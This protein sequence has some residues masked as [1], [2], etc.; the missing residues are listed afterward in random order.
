MLKLETNQ[1]A[2]RADYQVVLE[3]WREALENAI[4]F[5]DQLV[6]ESPKDPSNFYTFFQVDINNFPVCLPVK[7]ELYTPYK[8]MLTRAT[9]IANHCRCKATLRFFE[10]QDG[11]RKELTIEEI[12]EKI[13]V[14]EK[15]DSSFSQIFAKSFQAYIAKQ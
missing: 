11:V 10:V 8:T 6:I 4:G 3:K 12:L 13:A 2:E 5:P 1:T 15:V 9:G 14:A 7:R